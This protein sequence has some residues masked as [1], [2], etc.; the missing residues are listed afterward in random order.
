[1]GLLDKLLGANDYAELDPKDPAAERLERNRAALESF[2][3]RVHDK[4][5]VVPAD[6][7][8]YVFVGKPPGTFG[9][10]WFHGGKESNLKVLMK[11]HGLDAARAQTISDDLREAYK[12][13]K[14]QARYRYELAGRAVTVAPVPQLEREVSSIIRAVT[15]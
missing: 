13:S 2:A 12:R 1:M 10:V 4:L 9:I 3:A 8:T 15:G 7:G 5:E 11:D 6:D 14:G